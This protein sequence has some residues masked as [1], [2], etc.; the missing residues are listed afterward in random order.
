MSPMLRSVRL[1]MGL[2]SCG[3]MNEITQF[4]SGVNYQVYAN[5]YC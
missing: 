1:V 4:S 5:S 3:R 2:I